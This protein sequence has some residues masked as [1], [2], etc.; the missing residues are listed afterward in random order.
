MKYVVHLS[1]PESPPV[2][3][4]SLGAAIA[5]ASDQEAV[6]AEAYIYDYSGDALPISRWRLFRQF[7][8]TG[9]VA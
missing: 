9:K 3:F 4:L 2:E 1:D 8:L 7:A 6:G 5:Y